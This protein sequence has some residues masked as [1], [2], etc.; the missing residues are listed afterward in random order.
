MRSAADTPG[1]PR[2]PSRREWLRLGGLFSLGLTL[3][4]WARAAAGSTP[5][6]GKARSVIVVFTSGGQSQFETWDPK[7]DAPEEVRG[8]FPSPFALPCRGPC[9]ASICPGWPGWLTSTPSCAVSATTTSI[10]ARPATW[11]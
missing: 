10:T 11:R 9:F 2:T 6:F 4:A 5:G 7:P 8:V 3:P 1:T